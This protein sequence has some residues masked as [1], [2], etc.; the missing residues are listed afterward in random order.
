M[1]EE[2][3]IKGQPGVIIGT[4]A[5]ELSF[6]KAMWTTLAADGASRSPPRARLTSAST[7]VKCAGF[8]I[9]VRCCASDNAT[10]AAASTARSVPSACRGPRSGPHA[11]K[12]FGNRRGRCGG[13]SGICA[14]EEGG[15]GRGAVGPPAGSANSAATMASLAFSGKSR[16]RSRA[17]RIGLRPRQ[18]SIDRWPA[19]RLPGMAQLHHL[20]APR[21]QGPARRAAETREPQR[22]GTHA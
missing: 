3:G 13:V 20:G 15:P 22:R 8:G 12:T 9:C 19:R 14:S 6:A 2:A 7:T 11:W 1:Q 18:E 21:W 4:P 16:R 5:E 10:R 17:T